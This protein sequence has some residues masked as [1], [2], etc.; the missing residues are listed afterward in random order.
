MMTFKEQIFDL[1]EPEEK[2]QIKMKE[3]VETRNER[4]NEQSRWFYE[5]LLVPLFKEKREGFSKA[6][7]TVKI[8]PSLWGGIWIPGTFPKLCISVPNGRTLSY[9]VEVKCKGNQFLV[10][11]YFSIERTAS[12]SNYNEFASRNARVVDDLYDIQK[13]DIYKDFIEQ[14]EHNIKNVT[15]HLV[16]HK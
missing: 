10:V 11:R 8:S 15:S 16:H 9:R 3:E 6:G 4:F 12:N 1:L 14:Y 2:R 5:N 13:E 7:R